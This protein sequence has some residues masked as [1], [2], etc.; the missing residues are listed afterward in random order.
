MPII[1]DGYNLLR[2]VEGSDEGFGAMT[3]VELCLSLDKYLNLINEK[4]L[5]VFDGTGPPDK[6]GFDTLS[7]L[8]ILFSGQNKDADSVIET[9]IKL[10]TAARFL[11]VVSSDRRIRTAAMAK[12]AISLK[13]DEFWAQ[14]QK[15]LNRKKQQRDPNEKQH[16][17]NEG[18][19]EQW[20]KI[21]G[22]DDDLK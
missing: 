10:N 7:R 2:F 9:K 14:V 15:Q 12:K 3:D 16:G 6:T 5:I 17:L 8:E 20:M 21:F 1:I 11:T 4:G 19:T 18:E 13:S 22:I